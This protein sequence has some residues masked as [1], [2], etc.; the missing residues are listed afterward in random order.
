MEDLPEAVSE[1]IS[2]HLAAGRITL[3]AAVREHL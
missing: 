3:S 1:W 2:A